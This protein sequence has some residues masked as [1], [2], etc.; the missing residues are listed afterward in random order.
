MGRTYVMR[1]A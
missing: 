1:F